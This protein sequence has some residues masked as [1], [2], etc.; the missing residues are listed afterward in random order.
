MESD[1][2]AFQFVAA[3]ETNSGQPPVKLTA[4]QSNATGQQ[5]FPN[6]TQNCKYQICHKNG[7][8]RKIPKKTGKTKIRIKVEMQP[9]NQKINKKKAL[10]RLRSR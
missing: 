2:A 7:P 5:L 1:F 3:V 9:K 4:L 10:L 6:K 8:N